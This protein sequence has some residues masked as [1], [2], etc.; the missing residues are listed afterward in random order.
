MQPRQ[1]LLIAALW[2]IPAGAVALEAATRDDRLSAMRRIMPAEATCADLAWEPVSYCRLYS[3]GATLEIWSGAYGPGATLSFDSAGNEGYLL[4]PIVRAHFS[5]AGVSVATLNRCI[6]YE[7]GFVFES[8]GTLLDFRCHLVEIAGSLSL[9]I[10]PAPVRVPLSHL[11]IGA[12]G[13]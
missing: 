10:V 4:L 5:L 12:K 6:G 1:A 7:D 2:L 3:R 8:S 13:E 11:L 9:E